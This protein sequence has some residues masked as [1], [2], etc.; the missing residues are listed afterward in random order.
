MSAQETIIKE[1]QV[2]LV[3]F[4]GWPDCEVPTEEEEVSGFTEV[5]KI[6][7]NHYIFKKEGKAIVHCGQGHG[8]TGALATIL[9]R[10]L[11]QF[12]ETAN[13][14]SLIETLVALR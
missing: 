11:Q 1:A 7:F 6:L 8:R 10:V 13:E 4:S 2:E 3:H 5:V 12:Y 14:I 9:T